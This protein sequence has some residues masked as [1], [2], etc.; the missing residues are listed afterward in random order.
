MEKGTLVEIK[1]N[2]D[3]RL[4]V[5]DKP[6][7]KK[8]WIALDGNGNSHKIRPQKVEYQIQGQS[9]TSKEI[10]PFLAEV[11]K[12]LDSSSLDVAWELLSE[13]STAVSPS[14]LAEL[15]FEDNSP[16]F[17][18][19]SHLLLSEDKIYFKKKGDIYEPRPASQVEEIRHQL[20]I[21]AQ[22][23]QEK[24]EFIAKINQALAGAE[25][26]WS[27]SDLT[28]L[29]FVEKYILQPE[30]PP[31]QALEL[32]GELNLY[33]STDSAWQLLIDLNLW[34][35]H[36]NIFLKRSS[37]P[38]DFPS[39]VYAVAQS[40]LDR[41]ASGKELDHDHSRLDLTHHKVYTIDDETTSE[42]D[43]GLSVERLEDGSLRYWIHIA[44]PTRFV[45][46]HDELDL[47]A[48]KRATTLYL[49]TGMIPM[50]PTILATG[51]MSLIQGQICPALSF[52]VQL[53]ESGEVIDYQITS[54]W[55]KPTYR[56]TYQDAD[57]MVLLDIQGEEEIKQLTEVARLREKWR[58]SQGSVMI[59]MPEPIIKVSDNEEISIELLD[60]SYSRTVVAEMMILAG[61][62]A[63]RYC[64]EHNLPAPF[65]SQTQPELPPE[66]ELL[67]LPPGP[68]RACALRSRMPRSEMGLSPAPHA[69]LGL[70][71]YIQ[72]TSPIRRYSDLLAHFQIKAHL[73]GEDLPFPRDEI[74]EILYEVT[75]TSAEASLV[76]RQT[77]RYWCLE[78]LNQHSSEIWECLVL[79]WLREDENLALILIEDLGLEFPHKFDRL[80]N[81]GSTIK[82]QILYSDS[83]RDEIRFKEVLNT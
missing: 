70:P 39:Q 8:D 9:F 76:E 78:F 7:G 28:R 24:A 15:I 27:E 81:I 34:D 48:R 77:N 57:E 10:K 47:E 58:K 53:N 65:R 52:G 11:T 46:P 38:D 60:K 36:E 83:H 82:L 17:C 26:Q 6:E 44:D 43:D 74:Q 31:K 32:L 64:Q 3:R 40:I 72:V 51:P 56:L 66:E 18:Y 37:Y 1:V 80:V 71:Y 22:K 67:L 13:D 42:I 68:V 61:E 19:A 23:Q 35:K 69:S 62:V 14:E 25:I 33:K 75:S 73:R 5:I 45:T 54:S 12:Q 50:F 29:N 20:A 79:R 30:N 49:P 21:E 63:G 55:I 41:L 16:I 2:G 59:F 4:V